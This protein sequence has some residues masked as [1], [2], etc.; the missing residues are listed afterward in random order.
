M[1]YSRAFFFFYHSDVV[2]EGERRNR[3]VKAKRRGVRGWDVSRQMLVDDEEVEVSGAPRSHQPQRR[4][5]REGHS[6]H[7]SNFT[8]GFF[9]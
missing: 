8:K 4:L 7:D 6:S 1:L 3:W 2:G 9:F 5:R